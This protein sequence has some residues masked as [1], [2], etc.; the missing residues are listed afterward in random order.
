MPESLYRFSNMLLVVLAIT[1][2]RI[3]YLTINP[4]PLFM[5]EAQYWDW[6]RTLE[7]GYYSKPPMVAWMIALTTS[8]FG[9]AEWALR[10]GSP[11]AHGVT[12][13]V[14]YFLANELHSKKAGM[15]TA[16][17]YLLLPAV[18]VS[19][20]LI[21]STTARLYTTSSLRMVRTISPKEVTFSGTAI[22]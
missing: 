5:D 21:S 15:L 4:Y 13:I 16:I 9:D 10:V 1:T 12:A 17:T 7:W 22:R 11:V 18:T 6:A 3:Y 20:S 8:L 2:I 14:L 19:S